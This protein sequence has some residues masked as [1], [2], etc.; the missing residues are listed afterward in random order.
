LVT[1]GG[2]PAGSKLGYTRIAIGSGPEPLW[3]PSGDQPDSAVYLAGPYQGAPYSLLIVLQAQTGPFELGSV[4]L[5]APITVD[6]TTAQA[7]ISIKELP[8]IL[9]GIPLHYRSIRVVLDRAGFI[10]NPTSCEPTE[11]TGTAK[12]VDGSSARLAA[13]FQ[14]ADCAAL[15]FKPK[16]FL[17]L[18]GA[19][20]RNGHPALRATLRTDP[21]GAALK[22]AAFALPAGE[23]L[24]L[25]HVRELCSRALPV[26]QCPSSS[27]LGTLRLQSPSLQAPLEG[28][29][30]LR[31][32]S[33]RLPDLS[34]ELSSGALS[35]VLGGRT[36]DSGGRLGVSLESLPD[37]PLSSAV[38][39]LA[40]GRRGI[41]VNS[42]SLCGKRGSA[43]ASFSAHN[44]MRR[45]LRVRVGADRCS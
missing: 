15:S 27:R 5:R 31:V 28:P 42:R 22:S 16:L 24:D 4:I 30:Y 32:P 6:P 14:A 29:V 33:H 34:A 39:N 11:I 43:T 45:R 23:L 17:R 38:L 25:R 3:V 44:G 36:T 41:L 13:R 9:D 8:Q 10:R 19:L 1:S 21:S 40:G 26:G 7:S 12:A 2:C 18:S 37:I 20:G 35:F